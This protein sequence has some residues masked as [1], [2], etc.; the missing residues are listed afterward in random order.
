M[1]PIH[2]ALAATAMVARP[3]TVAKPALRLGGEWAGNR[4]ALTPSGGILESAE[5]LVSEAWSGRT[6]D[7][8]MERRTLR[9]H[10][11]KG[12]WCYV[13][14][15][16]LPS[17]CSGSV[18]LRYG[19]AMMEPDVLNARAW[20]LDTCDGATG[21]WRCETVFDGLG[22]DRPALRC[23]A[24]EC[25][26]ERTRVT[27]TLD[28][29]SGTLAPG[30]EVAVYQERCWSSAPALDEADELDDAFVSSAVG[31]ESFAS[32]SDAAAA[33]APSA[34]HAVGGG[35]EV[36][37][38]ADSRCLQISLSSGKGTLNTYSSVVV[39]RS[40]AGT[41]AGRSVFAEVEVLDD[42]TGEN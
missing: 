42:T 28:P 34:A 23:G 8:V 15:G 22:G 41:A 21:L 37:A 27:C 16:P 17:A 40:W 3:S 25:P 5:V 6:R 39:R 12:W 4:V 32:G 19:A 20:A 11:D 33:A 9:R 30:S 2:I 10:A 18:V 1:V 26:G 24:L 36:R 38:C 31:L 7:S 29:D 14:H 35:V 13:A